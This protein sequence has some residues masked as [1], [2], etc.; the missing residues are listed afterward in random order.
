[1]LNVLYL[2]K[3]DLLILK[4]YLWVAVFYGFFALFAFNYLQEGALSAAL[5]GV[6][7]TLISQAC[8]QDDKNR[9]EIMM[10]SLPLLRRDIVL[11]KYLSIFL[12]AIIG[13]FSYLLAQTLVS[14]TGM[15][16][17]AAKITL[18]GIL[19]AFSALIILVSIYFPLYF[20][21]GYLRSRMIGMLVFLA[22]F[23]LI[24]FVYGLI[25]H[26]PGTG[27]SLLLQTLSTALHR[28]AGWLQSQANWQIAIYLGA[29]NLFL[30]SLS[31]GTSLKFY[32]RR[33]F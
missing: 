21:L 5:V 27:H 28:L 11:A 19:G 26:S 25:T 8:A 7:Y 10:L 4:R 3:K 23:F 20:K 31:A 32:A 6:S 1:M 12:Y 17:N 22:C 30:L 16:I 18:P 24:P 15:P 14:V 29:L 9:S 2:V 13:L 33:E